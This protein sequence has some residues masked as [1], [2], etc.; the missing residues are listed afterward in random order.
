MSSFRAR[1]TAWVREPDATGRSSSD[2][3]PLADL[4]MA[5]AASRMADDSLY[6]DALEAERQRAYA[7]G[8]A[9]GLVKGERRALANA[10]ARFAECRTFVEQAVREMEAATNLGAAKLEENVAALAV[11]VAR[12][13]V[14]REVILDAGLVGTIVRRALS[15]F[16]V[17]QPVRIRIHPLDLSAL[18]AEGSSASAVPITGTR[19]ASWIADTRIARGGCLVEGTDRIVDGRVDTAL[20]RAYRRMA[21]IDAT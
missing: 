2:S 15:E 4:A 21:G 1:G 7:E 10:D 12:Q 19:D 3:W 9:A 13:I 20:E 17:D 5:E 11:I 14:E 6:A 16:P 8:E 18:S